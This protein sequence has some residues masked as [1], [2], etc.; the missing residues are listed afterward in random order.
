MDCLG[1]RLKLW[2]R[3]AHVLVFEKGKERQTECKAGKVVVYVA[4]DVSS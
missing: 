4:K 2:Q 1:L 3:K